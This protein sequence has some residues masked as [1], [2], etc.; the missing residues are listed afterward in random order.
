MRRPRPA[1]GAPVRRG[2]TT[3]AAGG[4]VT[5][6]IANAPGTA[7]DWVGLYD[8]N[9]V[10]VQWRYLDGTQTRP[11]SGI[12]NATITFTLPATPGTYHARLFNATYTLVA[13]SGTITTTVPTVTLGA[14]TGTA[15][16]TVTATIVNAPG[17][18]G[19]WVGLYDA[20]GV[21]VQWQ[22]LNGTHTLPT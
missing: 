1:T 8:A 15:G 9:G 2:A 5:A 6:T 18:P 20:N 17:T 16:G 3:G 10:P 19:D 21:P 7:G 12:A 14:A 4:T 13:T 22:Y 11:A